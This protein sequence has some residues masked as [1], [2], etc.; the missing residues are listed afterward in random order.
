MYRKYGFDLWVIYLNWGWFFF[1]PINSWHW[2]ANNFSPRY[3]PRIKHQGREIKEID[4]QLKE[5][6]IVKQIILVSTLGNV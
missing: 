6:L 4:Q 3:Q 1:Y 2:P 5:V